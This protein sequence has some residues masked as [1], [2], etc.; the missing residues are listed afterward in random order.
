MTQTPAQRIYRVMYLPNDTMLN[1]AW[2]LRSDC[3]ET[4][5]N[6]LRASLPVQGAGTV[7]LPS[8]LGDIQV[9]F[10]VGG[11]HA[12]VTVKLAARAILSAVVLA[13]A[14]AAAGSELARTFLDSLRRTKPVQQ[15][16]PAPER[17]FGKILSATERPLVG[18]ILWPVLPADQFTALGAFDVD[19]AAA[20]VWKAQ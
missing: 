8:S 5:A 13:D 11:G 14:N 7:A 4:R 2:V 12:L 18:S 10:T 6:R 15:F 17:A 16:A 3:D 20:L 9:Q 19:C 1:E